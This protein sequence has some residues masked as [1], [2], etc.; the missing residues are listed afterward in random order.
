M[1]FNLDTNVSKE[2]LSYFLALKIETVKLVLF[3]NVDI[4][5]DVN[6]TL[7]PRGQH[8]NLEHREPPNPVCMNVI[9][10]RNSVKFGTR[11]FTLRVFSNLNLVCIGQK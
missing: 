11:V 8:R 10:R 5:L 6:T 9:P 7:Q 4:C 1:D 3:L 2:M